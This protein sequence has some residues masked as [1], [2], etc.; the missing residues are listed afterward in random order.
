[1]QLEKI[2]NKIKELGSGSVA[3]MLVNFQ[4]LNVCGMPLDDLPD[5]CEIADFIDEFSDLLDS[6]SF[7]IGDIRD[8][9]YQIDY[10]WIEIRCF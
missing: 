8:F 1:M 9:L 3:K 2:Q 4:V 6:G 5:T 10:E 7:T